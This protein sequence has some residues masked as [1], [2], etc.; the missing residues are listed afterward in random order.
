MRNPQLE[1]NIGLGFALAGAAVV[2]VAH[3]L[4]PGALG[5]HARSLGWLV[6]L[7]GVLFGGGS[8]FVAQLNARGKSALRQGRDVLA[9]WTVDGDDWRRFVEMNARLNQESNAL[10]NAHSPRAEAPPGGVEV[11]VGKGGVLIDGDFHDLPRRGTPRITHAGLRPGRPN[12]LDIGL[13]FPGGV[14]GVSGVPSSA[15]RSALRFPIAPSAEAAAAAVI[16]HYQ[17]IASESRSAPRS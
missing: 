3:R 13:E 5:G 7:T 16:N 14:A 4:P 8:A 6:G 15:T 17:L 10:V 11:I 1:R 2:V 9:R 12:L